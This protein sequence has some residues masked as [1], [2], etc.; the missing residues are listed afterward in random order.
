M[1]YNIALVRGDGIGPE[2]I[3]SAV[4]V[5]D[6]VGEKSGLAF[7]F[8]DTLAGGCAIDKTGIPL[9]QETV[10]ICKKSDAVL[11]GAVG[12]PKWDTLPGHLRPERALLGL[13]SEL[14]LYAN[15]RPA[16]LY[17][18]LVSSCPLRRDIAEKGIDMVI[19]RELTGGM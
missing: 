5:L 14:G 17:K 6:R 3:S 11:L 7:S 18:P 12:G 19:V 16:V 15:I 1:T 2:I 9:P 10:D 8:R 13:R 4:K